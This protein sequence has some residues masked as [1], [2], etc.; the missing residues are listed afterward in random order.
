MLTDTSKNGLE[1]NMN[2]LET[3]EEE[4]SNIGSEDLS[5]E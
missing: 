4:N 3:I 5:F 1:L 2:D